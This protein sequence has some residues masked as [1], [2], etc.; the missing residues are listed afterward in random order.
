MCVSLGHL[1][2]WCG[3]NHRSADSWHPQFPPHI[4]LCNILC[5]PN[6]MAL[7][8]DAGMRAQCP[9]RG[10]KMGCGAAPAISEALACSTNISPLQMLSQLYARPSLGNLGPETQKELGPILLGGPTCSMF[11]QREENQK[12]YIWPLALL[13]SAVGHSPEQGLPISWKL[14]MPSLE[15]ILSFPS[16]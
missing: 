13:S 8:H 14:V 9:G 4:Y 15:T 6:R 2:L 12:T 3:H 10:R 1:S 7:T 11:V 5:V 16:K